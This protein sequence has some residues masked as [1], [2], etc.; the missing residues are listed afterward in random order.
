RLDTTR[1]EG[2]V[3]RTVDG[4]AR[5]EFADRVAK[6][7]RRGH[8]VTDTHWMLAPV[9]ANGLSPA[10]ALWDVRS[11]AAADVPSLLTA[12]GVTPADL[13]GLHAGLHRRF[14]DEERRAGLV[15]LA[16]AADLGVLHAVAAAVLA[17]PTDPAAA[18]ALAGNTDPAVAGALARH[19]DAAV[20]AVLAGHA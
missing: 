5:E 13:V 10:A 8:V 18:A 3:V 7:V 4:F 20:A 17:G 14:P 9:V 16:V 12:V 11:G 6:W 15:R 19:T 2:Y 1:Q